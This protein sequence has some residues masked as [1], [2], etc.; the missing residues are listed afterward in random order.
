MRRTSLL[1]F[2]LIVALVLLD[3]GLM[4]S[5]APAASLKIAP[6]VSE[7]QQLKWQLVA[8]RQELALELAHRQVCEGQRA[9]DVYRA[10][11]A[12]TQQDVDALVTAYEQANP[13]WTLDR[14]TGTPK[15]RD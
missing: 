10:T 13:G 6:P 11:I 4:H 2:V 9:P 15:G 5:Q 12:T 7:I 8:L 3:V 14:R 1:P